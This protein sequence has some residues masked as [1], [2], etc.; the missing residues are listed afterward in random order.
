MYT[1]TEKKQL[2][3]FIAVAYGL[4]Y[5]M[6]LLLWYGWAKGLSVSAFA[7]TQMLYPAAGVCL[8]YL[9]TCRGDQ[10]V[11][12]IF[13]VSY[14]VVTMGMLV[15][16]AFT[17]LLPGQ[18]IPMTGGM[19]V[20]VWLL[21]NQYGL[22]AGSLICLVCYFVSG[23]KRRIAYGMKWRNWK[24]SLACIGLFLLLYIARLVLACGAGGQLEILL[25]VVKRSDTWLI[26]ATLPI[27]FVLSFLA[28]FGEEYGWRYFLQPL[29]QKRFGLRGGVL[30]LGVVWGLWHLPLDFFFYVTPDKGLIQT[31]AQ[32]ITCVS[33]GIFLAYVYMKT[34]NIW[35]PVVIHFLNNNLAVVFSQEQT[36]QVLQNQ[37]VA[38]SMIPAAFILNG[39]FFGGFLLS[40]EFRKKEDAGNRE[41]MNI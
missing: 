7:S 10:Q 17:V 18:M 8:A 39:L 4:P 1:K 22:I 32:I 34:Q 29:L 16:T 37:E 23:K 40:R 30:L 38:W 41:T 11:P 31:T 3:I 15:T 33:L 25:D 2:F 26:L 6:G 20:P 19:A 28:F 35:V 24:A 12:R 5:L 9:F 21:V 27:S 14:L 36:A 13:Y